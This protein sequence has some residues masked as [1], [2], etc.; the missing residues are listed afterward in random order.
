MHTRRIAAYEGNVYDIRIM[1]A[2]VFLLRRAT[3]A[4][5]CPI[6][7]TDLSL[8]FF[9]SFLSL[10]AFK[11]L[12]SNLFSKNRTANFKQRFN[13]VPIGP[14]KENYSKST[15]NESVFPSRS[16]QS[17]RVRVE[18]KSINARSTV[19][20][21]LNGEPALCRLAT[22]HF[23]LPRFSPSHGCYYSNLRA[24]ISALRDRSRISY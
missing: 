14:N 20:S 12:F 6:R 17:V 19:C 22:F 5:R 13:R 9:S 4:S 24:T 3:V 1:R 15:E 2:W 18:E 11:P 10:P 7:A 23:S 8:A 21:R 16:V